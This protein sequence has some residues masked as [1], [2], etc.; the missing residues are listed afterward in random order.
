MIKLN[1][2][3]AKTHL[4]SYLARLEAGE[5]ILLCRRNVPIAE[6]RPLTA[7]RSDPR[8]IGLAK[9]TFAVPAS[10]F[11]PLPEEEIEAF[12]GRHA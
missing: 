1:V 5:T 2:H 11:E 3:E 9:D 7:P 8:P 10:F 4:S 6:I 12:E